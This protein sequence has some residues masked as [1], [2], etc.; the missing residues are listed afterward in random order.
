ME[1]RRTLIVAGAV[2][3]ALGVAWPWRR[4]LNLG[5]LPGDI[6]INRPG[7]HIYFPVITCLLISVILT[8]LF[9]I[10]RK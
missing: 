4:A 8:L 3:I 9:W 1:V 6:V 5:R 10:L 2:L 7:V